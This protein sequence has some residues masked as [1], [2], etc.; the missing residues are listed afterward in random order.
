MT[1]FLKTTLAA[2]ALL[3]ATSAPMLCAQ[4]EGP[5]PTTAVINIQSK[6]RQVDASMLTL[7]VDG[8]HVPID[9]LT[10]A[11]PQGI[12]LGILVDEGL[13]SSIGIQLKDIQDFIQSLPPN[14]KVLVGYMSNGTV[15]SESQDGFS[16]NHEAVAK[17]VRIPMS[18][19]GQSASPYFCLSDFVKRW[20]SQARATR[21]VLMITDGVDPYN[22]STSVLNQDSPYV[23][24]AQ[25]DV[26]RAGVVVYALYYGDAGIHGGSANF[27]GQSYLEQVTRATGGQSLYQGTFPPVAF[28]PFLKEFRKDLDESYILG[29]QAPAPREKPDTLTQIKV[30]AKVSGVKIIAPDSVHPGINE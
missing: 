10:P 13:R 11:A 1:T 15:R 24:S 18:T 5:Q 19:P 20:P 3:A 23:Q 9:S 22:G 2:A 30:K 16:A 8:K 6:G 14:V 27:S 26:Q 21:V 28:A 12:E 17:Q 25:E 4:Q 29:F 7:Q